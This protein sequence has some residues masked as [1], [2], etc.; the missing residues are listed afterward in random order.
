MRSIFPLLALTTLLASA[1][2]AHARDK[3]EGLPVTVTV[4]DEAGDPVSTA[5]VRHPDEADRHR[6]NAADGTWVEEALFLP[7]GTTLTF[8]PGLVLFL[9][10]SAPGFQTLI[11][12]YEVRKRKN[13]VEVHL[14][15]MEEDD[16]EIE[17]PM[18][19]YNRDE[20]WDAP[21]GGGPAN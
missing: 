1:S 13:F 7:D 18:M 12:Q 8:E 20:A 5:V 21:G 6:V 15:K 9:E 19:R 4:L 3:D 16:T 17:E 10:I 2:P 11:L 14:K